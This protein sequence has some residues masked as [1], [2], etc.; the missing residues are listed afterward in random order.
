MYKS[1]HRFQ[2]FWNTF[3]L[4]AFPQLFDLGRH[5][6]T[7]RLLCRD[8]SCT[9][10]CSRAV[11]QVSP[12]DLITWSDQRAT[13]EP[14][15]LFRGSLSSLL[16]NVEWSCKVADKR[17]LCVEIQRCTS[18]GFQMFMFSSTLTP[19]SLLFETFCYVGPIWVGGQMCVPGVIDLQ[20]VI[21]LWIGW[22]SEWCRENQTGLNQTEIDHLEINNEECIN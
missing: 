3:V 7:S 11:N 2:Y 10:W 18:K 15:V 19:K 4:Q 21:W 14:T 17:R 5:T 22:D 13:A 8:N 20:F 16:W 6:H 9:C 1:A 12:P